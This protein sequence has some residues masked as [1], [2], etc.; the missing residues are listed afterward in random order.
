MALLASVLV[1][2]LGGRIPL[3]FCIGL[4]GAIIFGITLIVSI[5]MHLC[6][7]RYRW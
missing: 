5:V 6:R 1:L 4:A 2:L 7:N 3:F